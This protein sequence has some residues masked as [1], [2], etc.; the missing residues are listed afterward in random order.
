[1]TQ[2]YVILLKTIAIFSDSKFLAIFIPKLLQK[3]FGFR[4]KVPITALVEPRP[5]PACTSKQLD[6][7]LQASDNLGRLQK[8]CL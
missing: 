4:S 1:M 7:A 3:E 6:P 8:L 5:Y 2:F